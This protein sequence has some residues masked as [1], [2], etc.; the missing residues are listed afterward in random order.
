MNTNSQEFKPHKEY[1]IHKR[2]FTFVIQVLKLV[3]SLPKTQQNI[4]FI[5]QITRSATSIGANDQEAD[6]STSRKQF[7]NSLTIVKKETKETNYWLKIIS[8]TNSG[9]SAQMVELITEGSEIEAI[10]S[11]IIQKSKV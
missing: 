6:G 8:A 11:S 4:I 10:I 9:F 7:F 5:G 3:Q 2:I 1:N